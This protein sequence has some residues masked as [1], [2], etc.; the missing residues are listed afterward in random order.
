MGTLKALWGQ[1]LVRSSVR[2]LLLGLGAVIVSGGIAAP[3]WVAWVLV[4]AGGAI[5][6][7]E[8]NP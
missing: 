1:T 3:A 2:G 4:T 5:A 6:A 8:R 7:G